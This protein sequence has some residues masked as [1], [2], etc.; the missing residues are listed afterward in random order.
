MTDFK[1]ILSDLKNSKEYAKAN[2]KTERLKEAYSKIIQK[3]NET[4]VA[5]MNEKE[6]LLKKLN[7]ETE[8]LKKE[9]PTVERDLNS[10]YIMKSEFVLKTILSR[11][12][13]EAGNEVGY[14]TI[15]NELANSENELVRQILIDH[16][17]DI[18]KMGDK[19]DQGKVESDVF[20]AYQAAKNSF[21]TPEQ[22]SYEEK[23]NGL[24]TERFKV[25]LEYQGLENQFQTELN[26]LHFDVNH[27]SGP[28]ESHNSN[29]YFGN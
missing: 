15:I 6:E 26:S 23:L 24:A 10:E 12:E 13:A 27:L 20:E 8:L 25:H 1:K 9:I 4:L 29:H 7:E 19:F 2:Y 14:L 5:V 16:Y 22:L 28:V 17:S 18:R 21:K 3:T 11:I